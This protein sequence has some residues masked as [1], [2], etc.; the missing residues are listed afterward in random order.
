MNLGQ[1]DTFGLHHTPPSMIT[2]H[3]LEH[4]YSFSLKE[5]QYLKTTQRLALQRMEQIKNGHEY[6]QVELQVH[7]DLRDFGHEI[8]DAIKEKRKVLPI[9]MGVV[10]WLISIWHPLF[11]QTALK[12]VFVEHDVMFTRSAI[13]R[14]HLMLLNDY[15]NND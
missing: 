10:Y 4:Q 14:I 8:N 1:I 2:K 6:T 13:E 3:Q 7:D 9:K 15:R 11:D 12:P 5:L